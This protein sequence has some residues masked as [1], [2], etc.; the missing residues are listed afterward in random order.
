MNSCYL[1]LSHFPVCGDD[2][3]PSKP[4][5]KRRQQRHVHRREMFPVIKCKS[6]D[7]K[8]IGRTNIGYLLFFYLL[9][10]FQSTKVRLLLSEQLGLISAIVFDQVKNILLGSCS[11]KMVIFKVFQLIFSF[12]RN[13]DS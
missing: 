5:N 6:I 8:E 7:W 13:K 9:H 10:L 12:S 3:F 2:K 4:K 1:S 11:T